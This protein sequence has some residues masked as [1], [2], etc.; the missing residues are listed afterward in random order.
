[1]I[2]I[3]SHIK[4]CCTCEYWHGQREVGP[5]SQGTWISCPNHLDVRNTAYCDKL[6]KEQAANAGC[7]DFVKW[8]CLK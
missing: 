7:L 3:D 8:R 4:R 1:M 6:K 5:Q 2:R